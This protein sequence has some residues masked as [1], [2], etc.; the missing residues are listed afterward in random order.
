MLKNTELLWKSLTNGMAIR[1]DTKFSFL[2][3][4]LCVARFKAV[5]E[6]ER[7]VVWS[8]GE[9]HCVASYRTPRPSAHFLEQL[10]KELSSQ[11]LQ[12]PGT[13]AFS[14][15]VRTG[16][17]GTAAEEEETGV[18]EREKERFDEGAESDK[19]SKQEARRLRREK[20]KRE[21]SC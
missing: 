9:T 12:T 7:V 20:R 10:E 6:C 13:V 8:F 1:S 18:M 16:R 17:G 11:Q 19:L 2:R 21:V 14:E 4:S 3:F 15:G 5:V